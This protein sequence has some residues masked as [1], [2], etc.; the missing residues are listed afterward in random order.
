MP[1]QCPPRS[2]LDLSA[3]GASIVCLAH[4]LLL[5]LLFFLWPLSAHTFDFPE[6]FHVASVL[7][8]MPVSSLA[9]IGGYRR[10]KHVM[11]SFC[12]AGGLAMLGVGASGN[13][14]GLGET[15]VTVLG[16]G[17]LIGAHLWNRRGARLRFL[18]DVRSV[19]EAS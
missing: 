15:A 2:L 6:S 16:S 11:P 8:A 3:I 1:A 13:V 18:S 5:P 9:M 12:A 4:C 7:L 10:H 14:T 17:L 19:A